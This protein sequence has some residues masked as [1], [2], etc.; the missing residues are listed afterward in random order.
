MYI[1]HDD[2]PQ[3]YITTGACRE[4]TAS[5]PP[6]DPL[7]LSLPPSTFTQCD[8]VRQDVVNP[9]FHI[10]LYP[11]KPGL[12]SAPVWSNLSATNGSI[13]EIAWQ[14]GLPYKDYSIFRHT[15]TV[16]SALATTDA[17]LTF[18]RSYQGQGSPGTPVVFSMS[19]GTKFSFDGTLLVNLYGQEGTVMKQGT[20]VLLFGDI[21]CF[22]V[23]APNAT[24]VKLNDDEVPFVQ[25]GDYVDGLLAFAEENKSCTS[26]ATWSNSSRHIAQQNGR[27]HQLFSSAGDIIYR[28]QD[29]STAQW[30]ITKRISSPSMNNQHHASVVVD[31]NGIV[32]AVWQRQPEQGVN[33][34]Q[35]WYAQGADNGETWSEPVI[36]PH[37]S[38]ID[39]SSTQLSIYPVIA[40][41][42][43]EKLVVVFCSNDGLMYTISE[44][45]GES[46]LEDPFGIAS[47]SNP[48][49]YVWYPSLVSI[50]NYLM[51]TYDYRY[52]G[53]WSRMFDGSAWSGE[54]NVN[55]AT[56]G[57]FDR[58]S[59]VSGNGYG[60]ALAAWCAQRIVG[61]Q[62]DPDYH[63]YLR[64]QNPDG[65]WDWFT[66]FIWGA[67]GVWDMYPSV[68]SMYWGENV[69]KPVVIHH[70]NF[71]QIL[72]KQ[73]NPAY[74]DWDDCLMSTSGLW[75][76][77]SHSEDAGA[78]P[79]A[80]WTNQSSNPYL[81]ELYG[82]PCGEMNKVT[83]GRNTVQK[84]RVV[85]QDRRNRSS[86]LVEMDPILVVTL[87]GDTVQLPFKSRQFGQRTDVDLTTVWD[88]LGSET[89]ILPSNSTKL[90][91][92]VRIEA[93]ASRDTSGTEG[94][95]S[96]GSRSFSVHLLRGTSRT[97]LWSNASG[98]SAMVE[99]DVRQFA[100]QSVGIKP[101]GTIPPG[102][103]QYLSVSAGD[104]VIGR[105]TENRPSLQ[106]AQ[107]S[108]PSQF[109]LGEVYPNPFNPST[110]I[111][112]DLPEPS[113]VSIII[114]DMLGRRV[115]ELVNDSHAA[116]YHSVQWN[117]VNAASGVYFVRFIATNGNGSVM[118][119]KINKAVLMK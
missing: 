89:I 61:G 88:Y 95:N 65:K 56:G 92:G 17:R 112:F 105:S 113:N 34:F 31:H 1:Y 72:Y 74:E 62:L 68:S 80:V 18:V 110:T 55:D 35:L 60:G 49:S 52:Y 63:I 38:S 100:G 46:W 108:L 86:L 30:D 44:D 107:G 47:Q 103:H 67:R 93:I 90:L 27:L 5:D 101:V 4:I 71:N 83:V 111:T 78:L 97:P 21:T 114:Y 12:P 76:N 73:Y 81:L 79:V 33:T 7:A 11:Y 58:H 23:Y 41:C 106:K 54:E 57:I 109:R 20:E 48:N 64:E 96:F 14:G 59:S 39:A 119:S 36:L 42:A 116:G 87:T 3:Q 85:I 69:W 6:E 50:S 13:L 22:R 32:H 45:G 8:I 19:H 118:F 91:L 37:C 75:A 9:Y 28:R 99:I 82:G 51:L 98:T 10:V 94:T 66:E 29:I 77:V 2:N 53:V 25:D 84:R 26:S 24:S 16:T 115:A 15:G 102:L 117:G 43:G 70:N 104:V 40:E